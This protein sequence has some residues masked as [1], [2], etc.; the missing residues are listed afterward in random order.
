MPQM[1]GREL[2]DRLAGLRPGMRV[3]FMSGY[4][5]GALATGGE[6]KPDIAYLPK[7]WVPEVLARRVREVLDEGKAQAGEDA[8]QIK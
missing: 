4:A 8:Q 5:E 7:P 1:S 3:L 6:L 2:A